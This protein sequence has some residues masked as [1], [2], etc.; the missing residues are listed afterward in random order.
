MI[1]LKGMYDS[2][3]RCQIPED[4]AAEALKDEFA[5]V[6]AGGHALLPG[7]RLVLDFG[8]RELDEDLIIC[9]MRELI[10]PSGAS[11]AAWITLD[12]KSQ[13]MMKRIGLP[14]VEPEAMSKS[15]RP[16]PGLVLSRTLRSG[17][18][19]EHRGDVIISGHV[20]DGAEIFASG[21]VAV[22][23]R[24][25][26]LVHAGSDGSE[27]VSVAARSMEAA[28]LRIG[29]KVCSIDR[30]VS[31]WGQMVIAKVEDGVVVVDHWPAVRSE[32]PTSAD[33]PQQPEDK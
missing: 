16:S 30:G 17:Q 10:W 9:V 3:I 12:A 5:R 26:G 22:L 29:G 20:N 1:R 32:Q 25:R 7:S 15:G 33:Q 23:G 14:T 8:G 31:W 28:Q 27:N 21:N 24:L 19:V 6:V 2:M 4:T 13:D 11:A 18:R